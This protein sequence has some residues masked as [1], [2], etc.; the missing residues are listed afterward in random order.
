MINQYVWVGIAV[1][2][3]A[4]GIGIGYAVFAN[5]YNPSTMMQNPQFMQRMM[6]D[7]QMMQTWMQTMSQNPQAMN[8][9]MN[10][11]MQNPQLMNQWMA[12]N[13]QMMGPMMSNWMQDPQLQQQMF[14]N[15]M[16]NQQ[17]M[18]QWMN[19]PQFQQNWM[20]PH[21]MQNWGM[22]PG[23]MGGPMWPQGAG[24]LSPVK[25]NQ[26]TIPLDAWHP[27]SVE[28]FKPLY[29]EVESGTTVTW[30][31]GD[32]IVHTVVDVNNAF[33][34]KLIQPNESWSYTFDTKGSYDYYCT[35]HPWMKGTIKV[36]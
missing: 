19:N 35:L 30:T 6:Q 21:M 15:M 3:F 34:S 33:D 29:I 14:N 10:S 22:G 7:P 25:T 1:G 9:W 26:I 20:Y 23:M 12:Q 36:N 27:K 4:A 2:V 18:Q 5:T 17:F 28:H 11:M 31:N 8:N 13:P 24:T 16:Q 32:K